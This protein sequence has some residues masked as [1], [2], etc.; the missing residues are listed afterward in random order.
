MRTEFNIRALPSFLFE[1]V[2]RLEPRSKD[3]EKDRER[4]DEE[5]GLRS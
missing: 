3:E 2:L 4:L 5:L 1:V